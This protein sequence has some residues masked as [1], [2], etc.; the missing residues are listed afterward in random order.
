MIEN[1]QPLLLAEACRL[2]ATT[3]HCLPPRLL[4]PT[5]ELGRK[6]VALREPL[7]EALGRR[8]AWLAAQNADWKFAALAGADPDEQRCWDEGDIEQRAAFLR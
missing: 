4:P 5:L 1:S 8:G 2:L 7:R 3:G 6:S